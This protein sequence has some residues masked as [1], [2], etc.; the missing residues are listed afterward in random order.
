MSLRWIKS[1]VTLVLIFLRKL[2]RL[3]KNLNWKLIHKL[4]KFNL[5][6]LT[7]FSPSKHRTTITMAAPFQGSSLPP[8]FLYSF[9][10]QFLYFEH[11]SSTRY[12]ISMILNF[13][14]SQLIL[15]QL[16]FNLCSGFK[17][18]FGSFHIE[19]IA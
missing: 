6:P 10:W 8:F 15:L 13:L 3:S 12:P 2:S 19:I 9:L 17:T 4:Q 18:K 14:E 11:I 7:N 16:M 5:V 1:Y